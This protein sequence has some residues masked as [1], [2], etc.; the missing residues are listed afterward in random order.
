MAAGSPFYV[1][2]DVIDHRRVD[3]GSLLGYWDSMLALRDILQ[4]II[5]KI[6]GSQVVHHLLCRFLAASLLSWCRLQKE[7]CT[8]LLMTANQ[9]CWPAPF[10]SLFS[11]YLLKT[12][13]T[14]LKNSSANEKSG[15][16]FGE[17]NRLDH[18][19][20]SVV[21][22]NISL[23][24]WPCTFIS[25][26]FWLHQNTFNW[27]KA[28]FTEESQCNETMPDCTTKAATVIDVLFHLEAR[29]VTFLGVVNSSF[30]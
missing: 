13:P 22:E 25:R 7:N 19:L 15:D 28:D 3:L 1:S 21:E 5:G 4:W 20:I 30:H 10:C 8:R 23:K 6:S 11:C 24:A 12:R 16:R 14:Y 17:P 9:R 2:R 29:R 18:S 27:E 26:F